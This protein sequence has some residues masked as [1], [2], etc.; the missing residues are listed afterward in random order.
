MDGVSV[1]IKRMDNK[2]D[3][4]GNCRRKKEFKK[5]MIFDRL[6]KI[7]IKRKKV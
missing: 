7:R 5:T 2:K 6:M 1:G 3:G 4:Q